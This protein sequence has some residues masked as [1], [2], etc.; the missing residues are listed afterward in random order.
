MGEGTIFM[1]I[2]TSGAGTTSFQALDLTTSATYEFVVV[3]VNEV[4]ESQPSVP[5]AFVIA[6]TPGQPA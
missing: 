6:T 1:Q 3:A 4:G 2:G 5:A